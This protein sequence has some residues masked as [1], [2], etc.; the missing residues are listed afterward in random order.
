M[1]GARVQNKDKTP[2]SKT[3]RREWQFQAHTTEEREPEASQPGLLDTLFPLELIG[4]HTLKHVRICVYLK[5]RCWVY[6]E[7]D[8]EC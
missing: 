1:H 7:I 8:L 3:K 6:Q 4:K 2:S 5:K